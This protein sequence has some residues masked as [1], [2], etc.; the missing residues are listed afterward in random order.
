MDKNLKRNVIKI[1]VFGTLRNGGRLD[2]YMDGSDSK[3]LHYAQGQ[4]MKSEI[5]S[6]YIDFD[7][8]GVPA[9]GELHYIDYPGLLRINHLESTSGEFPKGYDLDLLP[10]WKLNKKGVYSYDE[11]EQVLAFFY[12][13]RNNPIKIQSGDWIKQTMPVE[14][15]GRFLKKSNNKVSAGKLIK[16]MKNY[17]SY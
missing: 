12:K 9:F 2:Y 7:E 5:G 17:L 11:S 3:G 8:K 6:A 1:F 15:I 14:E 16:H 13:R 10:V 4:L